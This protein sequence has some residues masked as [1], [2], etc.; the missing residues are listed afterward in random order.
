MHADMSGYRTVGFGCW[1]EL[2]STMLIRL[3]LPSADV[4]KELQ[5]E[6]ESSSLILLRYPQ[7]LEEKI[8]HLR[9][10]PALPSAEHHEG[11]RQTC[12]LSMNFYTV[13]Y[14]EGVMWV[15]VMWL[16]GTNREICSESKNPLNP[17]SKLSYCHKFWPG[18][19][20]LEDTIAV[21]YDRENSVPLKQ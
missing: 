12:R 20:P 7:D 1:D 19:Q 10:H 9:V 2:Y 4:V 11:K 6:E 14:L 8:L 5:E 18:R 15:L 21:K 16:D 3:Q 17:L 13:I